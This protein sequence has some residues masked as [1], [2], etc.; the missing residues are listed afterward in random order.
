MAPVLSEIRIETTRP[1]APSEPS[2]SG[3]AVQ[4][5]PIEAKPAAALPGRP[6][7]N[8]ERLVRR[9]LSDPIRCRPIRD[10]AERLYRDAQQTQSRLIALVGLGSDSLTHETL[11][12]IATLL[13]ERAA[14]DVLLVDAD[15]ARR[16][17]SEALESGELR[18]LAELLS[19]GG[20]ARE[21]CRPMATA[22][23]TFLPAGR[24]RHIDLS[25]AGPRLEQTLSQLRSDFSFVLLDGGRAADLAA[26]ALARQ[27]DGTYFVVRLGT[28]EMSEAQVSLASF[29]AAGARVLGC[30]A[31]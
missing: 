10:M 6:E 7:T 21:F 18:G 19:E 29:R 17:L 24:S 12:Y 13:V 5:A 26:S 27:A 20:Q 4:R 23:L 14:G 28:V 3:F 2:D 22:K 16:P 11:L 25:T 9:T 8:V 30:I 1:L 31:T 15:C